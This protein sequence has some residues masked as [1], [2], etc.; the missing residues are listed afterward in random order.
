MWGCGEVVTPGMEDMAETG[1]IDISLFD[2]VTPFLAAG[3]VDSLIE[4]REFTGPAVGDVPGELEFEIVVNQT[5][6]LVSMV[7]MLGPSP[8]WFVGVDGQS[9]LVG[10]E[11]QEWTESLAVPLPLY[12]GGSKSDVIP[13]MGGPDIIP[14]NP[15]SLV[16]YDTATGTYLPS[17]EEQI[18]GELVFTR[19]E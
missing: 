9:L 19:I 12:D 7:S 11:V 10:D 6:P 17:T 8:D 4:V 13:V 14:P 2:E 15:V 18:V 1:R 3:S 5:H 16:A